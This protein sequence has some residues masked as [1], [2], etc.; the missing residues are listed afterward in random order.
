MQQHQPALIQMNDSHN[1]SSN[2]PAA[3]STTSAAAAMTASDIYRR[4]SSLLR[5]NNSIRGSAGVTDPLATSSDLLQ[6]RRHRFGHHSGGHYPSMEPRWSTTSYH[7]QSRSQGSGGRMGGMLRN[8]GGRSRYTALDSTRY[9]RFVKKVFFLHITSQ[10]A[11]LSRRR[12][13]KSR[14]VSSSLTGAK[15]F[16]TNT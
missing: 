1:A 13:S 2:T 10:A 3:A 9:G 5:H 14:V 11:L 8:Y 12:T 16:F 6:P 15:H 4:S 7:E